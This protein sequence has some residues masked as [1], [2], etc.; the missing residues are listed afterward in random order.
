MLAVYGA[1]DWFESADAVR[2]IAA[3]VNRIHPGKAEF[4]ELA[5]INHH[6]TRY[7]SRTAAYREQGGS[8]DPG[9]F[10]QTVLAWLDAIHF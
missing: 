6:F 2:L 5:A 10:V 4:H 7:P 8:A 1:Y 9:E 3:T